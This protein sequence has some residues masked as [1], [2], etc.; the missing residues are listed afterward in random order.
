MKQFDVLFIALFI[1]VGFLLTPLIF[2]T[3]DFWSGIQK[4]KQRG[5]RITSDGWT[6]TVSKLARYYNMLFA[7][8]MID[9][10]QIT[11]VWFLDTYYGYHMPIFPWLTMLG[12]FIVAA[13]EIKSIFEKA[14]DK[15]K[16]QI[17]DVSILAETIAKNIS[18]PSDIAQAVVNY[19]NNNNSESNKDESK[20]TTN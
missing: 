19:M 6:R 3:L 5:E 2:A 20:S 14:E 11:G 12:A 8:V 13:I 15:V 18:S 7:F 10:M 17:T 4:A 9:A 1:L 16:K